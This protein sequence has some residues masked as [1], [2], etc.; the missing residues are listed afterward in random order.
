MT[1][2]SEDRIRNGCKKLAKAR[3]GST[4]G[5]LDNFFKVTSVTPKRKVNVDLLT[6]AKNY[7]S[8]RHLFKTI[9]PLNRIAMANNQASGRW[10]KKNI[11]SLDQDGL[12]HNHSNRCQILNNPPKYRSCV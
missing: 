6:P 9:T 10:I 4:Q 12:W 7:L 8:K 1:T 5:R 2:F 3:S 11:Q